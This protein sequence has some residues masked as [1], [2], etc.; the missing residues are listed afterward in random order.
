MDKGEKPHPAIK[1]ISPNMKM[2]ET[3]LNIIIWPAI[4]FA[5]KRIIKAAG[6]IKKLANSIGIKMIFTNKG[7]PGGQ[8]IWPQK[9][10]LVLNNI[11]K[12]AITPNTMVKAT[13]PVTLAEPGNNP[14]K[15]L[16]SIKKNT[17]SR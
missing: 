6:L 17:V 16:I 5:N 3:K 10:L 9:W 14:T 13:L 15:Q 7:T 2:S 12:K 8:K 11:I 1:F 4:I